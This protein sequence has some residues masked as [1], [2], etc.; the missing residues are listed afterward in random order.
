MNHGFLPISQL[1]KSVF[2]FFHKINKNKN[3]IA[4]NIIFTDFISDL[5]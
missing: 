3:K 2:A 5:S 4:K 1:I